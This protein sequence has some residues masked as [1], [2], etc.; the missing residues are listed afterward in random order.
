MNFLQVCPTYPSLLIVPKVIDD[1]TIITS[2][3]FRA[4]GRF[5]VLSYRHS[6]G[7]SDNTFVERKQ[8]VNYDFISS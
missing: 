4:G 5:P 3:K 7:V 8:L 2:A 1:D 6:V